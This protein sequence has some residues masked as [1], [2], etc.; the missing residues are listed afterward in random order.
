MTDIL[1]IALIALCLVLLALVIVL[2]ARQRTSSEQKDDM[3]D[4]LQQL[5]I[6]LASSQREA[7]T[8]L[9]E[10]VQRN[11]KSLGE[12]VAENQVRAYRT[13]SAK[14]SEMDTALMQK[15]ELL[16]KTLLVSVTQQEQRMKTFA[17]E[18]EQKLENIRSTMEKK[19]T[20]IQQDTNNRLNEMRG[21]V[22]EKLQ[23]T[24]DARM[25][26][27]FALV[28]ERLEQ[29]YKGLGEMQNLAVG[30][31]DLKKVLSNVK[32]R[33]VLGEIQLGAILS[34]ILAPEMYDTNVITVNSGKN[35]VEY[36]V[37][38][39][40]DDGEHIYLPIDSKFP[41]DAYSELMDA[42]DS[43]QPERVA[44]AQSALKTRIVGF[45]KDIRAKYV[46]PPDTTEFAIMFLPTE[47]LYAEAVKLGLI[48]QLQHDHRISLAGPS[49]MAAMLNSL[50]MGFRSVAIQKR[51]GEVWKV[52]SAV[53]TEFDKFQ[54][55]LEH[56]QKQL[57]LANDDLDQLVG[58]RTRQI[59]S[60]LKG[61]AEMPA[62]EA[63]LY[64]PAN[65]PAD[66]D[67]TAE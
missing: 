4:E 3:A 5:R 34:E 51:S 20:V 6:E 38:L 63:K 54:T 47:G 22:D 8:E 26:Q 33:G 57:N 14:L 50:Q 11:V 45:A 18:N 64:L 24:L 36:A 16:Q 10:T 25:T 61:V 56:T 46:S 65:D 23:K 55:V 27:S 58:V 49:T 21:I 42:Y 7:R 60:K 41:M 31:G 67:G 30:V 62:T 32:T 35:P 52:L 53:K 19:L 17:T 44:A 13:Q 39:P 15:Q 40:A 28:N 43:A 9:S 12:M 1:L 29:V 37:K 66:D 59:R 48:E 2:L